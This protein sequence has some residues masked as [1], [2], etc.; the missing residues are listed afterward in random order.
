M[1][2]KRYIIKRLSAMYLV[3]AVLIS[4]IIFYYF[5]NIVSVS[6]K[7]KSLV[8]AESIKAG[9]TAHMKNNTM[10]NV[11]YFTNEIK[12]MKGIKRLWIQRTEN[13]GLGDRKIEQMDEIQKLV[14]N[15]KRSQFIAYDVEGKEEFRVSVP[16]IATN[17]GN[18]KC[19]TCHNV[20][21]GTV[22]GI[23][24]M[25]IDITKF[26]DDNL[27]ILIITLSVFG[28]FVVLSTILLM[29][30]L[31]KAVAW[32]LNTLVDIFSTYIKEYKTINE[33]DFELNEFKVMTKKMNKII[34][35]IRERDEDIQQMNSFLESKVLE[36]TQ[37]IEKVAT[38]DELT[39]LSNR[40]KLNKDILKNKDTHKAVLLINL[41]DF[42]QINNVY[43]MHI[44]DTVLK[45]VSSLIKKLVPTTSQC[46]RFSADEFIVIMPDVSDEEAIEVANLLK[47]YVNKNHV[48]IPDERLDFKI[49]FTIGIAYG[50]DDSI[51]KMA[52]IAFTEARENGKNR[53][54]VYNPDSLVEEQHS[55]NIYWANELKKAIE[56]DNLIPYFQP[57]IN[58]ET[59]KPEKF[60]CLVRMVDPSGAIISPAK[61]LEPAKRTGTASVITKIMIEKSFA[62]FRDRPFEFSI[63][64]TDSDFKEGTLKEYLIEKAREYDIRHERVVIEMLESISM[65]G[66]S[67]AVEQI[68]DLYNQGFKIAIDD[69]GADYSNFSRLLELKVDY[70]KIDGLFIKN[71]HTDINS[72]K[73]VSSIN[74][75]A[76]SV[77]A[78][79]IAE[80]VHSKEVHDKVVEL[81]IEYSQGYYFSP[82]VISVDNL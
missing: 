46:Y 44:G 45:E 49:T 67:Y 72:Y 32:P 20:A 52:N 53:F 33:N 56:T 26:K 43:G 48:T 22:L 6:L 76:K 77:N 11:S 63:N 3:Y 31:K 25:E 12:N 51:V 68:N 47:D 8:I 16:Y 27:N 66:S 36:R 57:I 61:F 59:N 5:N 40:T 71:I 29:F 9:L 34:M 2:I 64:I 19:L 60:E 17:K 4:I 75:F 35:E 18:L 39:G 28:F 24:N 79:V 30:T 54:Q 14:I 37:E 38:T 74:D 15:T 70:I 82:P 65:R 69:F 42:A 1:T 73:I 78:K 21:E 7:E 41:D 10:D 62:Y 23:L 81:G 55:N 80:F 50:N 58:N 13:I